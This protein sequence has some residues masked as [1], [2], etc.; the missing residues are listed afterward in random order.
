MGASVAC[1]DPTPESWSGLDIEI[2][3]L[4]SAVDFDV[5]I[6]YESM[7]LT[8]TGGTDY[9]AL[10]GTLTLTVGNLSGRFAIDFIDDLVEEGH[11]EF[12]VV[13]SAPEYTD[14]QETHIHVTIIDEES[15]RV[16]VADASGYEN[17]RYGMRVDIT[18]SEVVF[19]G[20]SFGVGT[21]AGTAGPD[22]DYVHSDDSISVTLRPGRRLRSLTLGHYLLDDLL[23]EPNE[24]YTLFVEGHQYLS[25]DRA[26]ATMTILDDDDP[27]SVS[28]ADASGLEDSIGDLSFDVGPEHGERQGNHLGLRD[29]GR[30][31]DSGQ[32]LQHKYG[33]ADLRPGRHGQEYRRDGDSRR[34]PRIRREFQRYD[35]E[36]E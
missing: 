24:T 6:E 30:H 27:P 18:F 29:H 8:A 22:D 15:I 20:A 26:S 35:F 1:I 14:F 36:Y 5:V 31:R 2:E 7:D 4:D 28:I 21:T 17:F 32:R 25:T 13:A 9:V 3:L 33:E 11:E 12:V 10:D 19:W 23:D 16:S 34:C